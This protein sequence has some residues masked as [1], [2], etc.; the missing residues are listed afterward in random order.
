MMSAGVDSLRKTLLVKKKTW[1]AGNPSK[2]LSILKVTNGTRVPAKR[3]IGEEKKVIEEMVKV[4]PLEG[5]VKVTRGMVKVIKLKV[6]RVDSLRSP[7]PRRVR[8]M[9]KDVVETAKEKEEEETV[10]VKDQTV[11]I[12]TGIASKPL[13]KKTL[14]NYPAKKMM[15]PAGKLSSRRTLLVKKVM[16]N[17]GNPS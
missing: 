10:K 14:T 6:E 1:S 9:V 4:I 12:K 11:K 7:R 16:K 8:R 13:A 2:I 17:A 5:K 15:R 3:V